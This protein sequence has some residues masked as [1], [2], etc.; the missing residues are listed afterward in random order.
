[1]VS[2]NKI[3]VYMGQANDPMLYAP[4]LIHKKSTVIIRNF[5]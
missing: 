1:M 4:F 5:F 3:L 2:R